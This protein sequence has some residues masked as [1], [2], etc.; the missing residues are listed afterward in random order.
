MMIGKIKFPYDH[1][2]DTS[3]HGPMGS[4]VLRCHPLTLWA[5]AAVIGALVGWFAHL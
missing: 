1:E 3:T 5:I 4:F 2:R